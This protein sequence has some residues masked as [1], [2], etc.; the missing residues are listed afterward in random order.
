MYLVSPTSIA[1]TGSSELC[2]LALARIRESGGQQGLAKAVNKP[3]NRGRSP[4]AI[5][6][7]YGWAAIL[8]QLIASGA[9]ADEGHHPG[10]ATALF[11][12]AELGQVEVSGGSFVVENGPQYYGFEALKISETFQIAFHAWS[13]EDAQAVE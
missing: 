11:K 2:A 6:A 4:L 3:D 9:R 13:K 10:G 7:Q 1:Q 12:A 8:D 5:A